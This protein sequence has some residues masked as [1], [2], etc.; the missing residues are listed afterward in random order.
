MSRVDIFTEISDSISKIMREGED[1]AIEL[2]QSR[3]H[4]CPQAKN[5]SF[6]FF[7]TPSGRLKG[8]SNHSNGFVW[9]TSENVKCCMWCGFNPA[10]DEL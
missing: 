9:P 7:I 1:S 3:I 10:K 4:E 5:D 6:I 8:V 2:F